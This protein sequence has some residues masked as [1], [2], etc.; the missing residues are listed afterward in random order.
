[1][2][3]IKYCGYKKLSLSIIK[4]IEKKV[5]YLRKIFPSKT[6][7]TILVVN[8]SDVIPKSILNNSIFY[9]VIHFDNFFV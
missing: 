5:D 4:E 2:V 8:N 9:K 6:I 7:Q 3:E 1:M